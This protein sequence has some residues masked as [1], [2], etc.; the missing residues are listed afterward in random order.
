MR[1]NS[2]KKTIACDMELEVIASIRSVAHLSRRSVGAVLTDS[3]L[4]YCKKHYGDIELPVAPRNLARGPIQCPNKLYRTKKK[5]AVR[6][7]CR[8]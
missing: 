2:N 6:D 5:I 4:E 7:I 1:K 3:F 8:N